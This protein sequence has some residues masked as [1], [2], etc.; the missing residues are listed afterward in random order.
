MVET[1]NMSTDTMTRKTIENLERAILNRDD[2]IKQLEEENKRLK[3]APSLRNI[4]KKL[5]EHIRNKY[6]TQYEKYLHQMQL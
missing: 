6:K 3:D 1:D 5:P 2:K 4:G